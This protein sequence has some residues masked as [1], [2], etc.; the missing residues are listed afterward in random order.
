MM[1]DVN[2]LV[3]FLCAIRTTEH[4]FESKLRQNVGFICVDFIWIFSAHLLIECLNEV[5]YTSYELIC[6]L[7][8]AFKM[9]DLDIWTSYLLHDQFM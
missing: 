9:Y 6:K 5:I 2:G 8:A 3:V 1:V 4:G 7:H